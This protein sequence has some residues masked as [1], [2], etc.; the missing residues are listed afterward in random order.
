MGGR[1]SSPPPPPPKPDP[2][3]GLMKQMQIQQNEQAKAAAEAQKQALIKQQEVAGEQAQQMGEQSA[4][5]QISQF[6][7]MQAIRDANALAAAKEAQAASAQSATG[8]GFDIGRSREEALGNLGAIGGMIPQTP[9]NITSYAANPALATMPNQKAMYQG[10]KQANIFTLPS[11][12]DI[13][14]GGS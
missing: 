7:S 8:G 3:I 6:G 2:M 9:S 10:Q 12:S 1:K 14:F 4:Q 11:Y 5:Q 13:K